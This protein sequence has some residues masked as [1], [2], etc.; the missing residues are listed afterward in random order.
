MMTMMTTTMMM[1]IIVIVVKGAELPSGAFIF[2]LTSNA[3]KSASRL[4][5]RISHGSHRDAITESRDKLPNI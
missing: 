4:Y 3:T 2:F 1:M 5:V